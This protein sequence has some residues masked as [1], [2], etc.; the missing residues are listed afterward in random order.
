MAVSE[1]ERCD[2]EQDL[3]V[4]LTSIILGGFNPDFTVPLRTPLLGARAVS[5]TNFQLSCSI[6]RHAQL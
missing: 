3:I 4:Y 5:P 2:S 1:H 6:P